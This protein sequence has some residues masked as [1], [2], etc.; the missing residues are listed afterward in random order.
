MHI[1]AVM[2]ILAQI[3]CIHHV[4][5][6]DKSRYWILLLLIPWVG[7]IFYFFSE[8][9]PALT[10]NLPHAMPSDESDLLDLSEDHVL[11][12]I[13]L[14]SRISARTDISISSVGPMRRMNT[15]WVHSLLIGSNGTIIYSNGSGVFTLD[16]QNKARL[17]LKGNLIEEVVIG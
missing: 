13:S 3:Y 11:S 6:N 1:I 4:L 15:P 8:I 12:Y 17:I 14:C 2:E 9:L 7:I 10:E 5:K 16:S